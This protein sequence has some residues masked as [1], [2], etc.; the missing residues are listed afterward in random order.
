M[1]KTSDEMC[2][3]FAKKIPYINFPSDW[4]IQIIPPHAGAT[5]R[6]VVTNK[7]LKKKDFEVSVY[8]DCYRALGACDEPY[9]EI[10]PNK[11][12]TNERFGIDEVSE[13]LK[14]IKD[15]IAYHEYNFAGLSSFK[16]ELREFCNDYFPNKEVKND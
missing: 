12:C 10:Y 6:F 8:L 13:M 15:S 16:D 11:N 4:L 9:W 1:T 3:E 7:E 5:V 2:E 14:A